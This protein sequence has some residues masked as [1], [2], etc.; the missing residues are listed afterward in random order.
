MYFRWIRTGGTLVVGG[1]LVATMVAACG[2]ESVKKLNVKDYAVEVCDAAKAYQAKVDKAGLALESLDP[3][4]DPK[5]AKKALLDYLSN[6]VK[7]AYAAS[8]QQ[9]DRIGQP[10]IASGAGV[11][12]A[13]QASQTRGEAQLNAAIKKVNALDPNAKSF[14]DDLALIFG[15]V[16]PG[17]LQKDLAKLAE[18]DAGVQQ[19]I[20]G[21]TADADCAAVVFRGASDGATTTTPQTGGTKP[22]PRSTPRPNASPAERWVTN[23]CVAFVSFGED[24]ADAGASFDG[25]N[26]ASATDLKGGLVTFLTD[27]AARSRQFKKDVDGLGVAPVKDGAKL[28]SELSATAADVVKLFDGA[29]SDAKSLSTSSLQKLADQANRISTRIADGF[30]EIG[31]RFDAIDTRYDTGELSKAADGVPECG[32]LFD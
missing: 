12:K 28:Q 18:T 6:D 23:F 19:L 1:L 32:Q 5:G 10:D 25:A 8:H 14:S 4:K 26:A 11:R 3:D 21:I 29:L 27:A 2:G 9:I 30:D 13:F 17:G 22:V 16:E 24:V 15:S 31:V 20:D 7:K